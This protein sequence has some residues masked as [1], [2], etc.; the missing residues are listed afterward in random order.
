MTVEKEEEEHIEN[1]IQFCFDV[2]LKEAK[3]EGCKANILS[4]VKRIHKQSA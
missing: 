3:L 1:P 4:Y 2:I